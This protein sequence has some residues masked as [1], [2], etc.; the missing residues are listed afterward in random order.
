M[1]ETALALRAAGFRCVAAAAAM[2]ALPPA[3][4][5][6]SVTHRMTPAELVAQADAIVRV[7]VAGDAPG[8]TPASHGPVPLEVLEVMKG[9]VASKTFSVPGY[10][11]R[12]EGP[13][14]QKPPYKS[15]RPGGL[16]GSCFA[17]DYK[18]GGE[19]L[20]FLREGTPYWAALAAVNEEVRGADDP[21]VR[22]VK[23]A[24]RRTR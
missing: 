11:N 3:A 21:W 4:L 12:Y 18:P 5:A 19:Y 17:H 15:V 2:A 14:L 7:R 13:N 16:H 20:L 8:A 6:C 10:T 24:L 1:L 22:W 9:T 23:W